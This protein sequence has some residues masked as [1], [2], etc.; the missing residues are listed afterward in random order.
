MQKHR[1]TA[2]RNSL[3]GEELRFHHSPKGYLF[4][5]PQLNEQVVPA[6]ATYKER[7]AKACMLVIVRRD[8][9]LQQR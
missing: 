3:G 4:I 2:A 1:K 7:F 6:D 9:V 8:C 5:I